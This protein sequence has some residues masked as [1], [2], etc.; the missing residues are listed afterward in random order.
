M[1]NLQGFG[2]GAY[3]SI[4]ISSIGD[5]FFVSVLFMRLMVH[6]LMSPWV[7][8]RGK[9][10]VFYNIVTLGCA[11]VVPILGGWISNKYNFQMQFRILIS[12]TGLALL[13][14]IFACLE[15]T[16][17]RP[18]IYET[19]MASTE[20][21]AIVNEKNA[22]TTTAVETTPP[23]KTEEDASKPAAET[24]REN[25]STGATSTSTEIPK[26]YWEELKPFSGRL[27]N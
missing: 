20:G 22:E 24:A 9:R 3:E 8:E 7:H 5:L 16:Y 21:V 11:N 10:I 12:F 14:I 1:S 23:A 25:G 19:D 18:S 27:S 2:N 4:V 6:P 17:V 15:H 26:T 13:A